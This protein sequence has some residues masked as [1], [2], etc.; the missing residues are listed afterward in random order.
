MQH[1]SSFTAY[2][3]MAETCG[4]C[5]LK[6][7]QYNLSFKQEMTKGGE[8]KRASRS[9]YAVC[10]TGGCIAFHPSNAGDGLTP[11]GERQS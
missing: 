7:G 6:G 4:F 9:R 3:V 5:V 1:L 2:C 10:L 11:A 8:W